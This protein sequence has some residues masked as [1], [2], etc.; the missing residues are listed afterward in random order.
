M[1]PSYDQTTKKNNNKKGSD[2]FDVN[3]YLLLV[4]SFVFP[5]SVLDFLGKN[6]KSQ[7][8]AQIYER[9]IEHFECILGG[10]QDVSGVVLELREMFVPAA[11]LAFR[12]LPEISIHPK[13]FTEITPRKKLDPASPIFVLL[14]VLI[15][16]LFFVFS[17]IVPGFPW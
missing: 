8:L 17:T 7:T 3:V 16:R 2:Y 6:K 11:A 10:L 15:Q 5:R 14:V 13:L 9:L 4:C 12:Q 1:V